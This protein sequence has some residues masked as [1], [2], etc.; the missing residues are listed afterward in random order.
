MHVVISLDDQPD[1]TVN[2]IT[3]AFP[4]PMGDA[5]DKTPATEL[6]AFLKN[7]IDVWHEVRDM[8]NAQAK[9]YLDALNATAHLS[10]HDKTTHNG[11]H[12]GKH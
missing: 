10:S 9:A 12:H 1:G 2:V 6:A 3:A 5:P 8:N 4:A 11:G 7:A